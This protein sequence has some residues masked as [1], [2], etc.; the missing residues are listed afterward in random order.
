MKQ[1]YWWMKGDITA[2]ARKMLTLVENRDLAGSFGKKGN[3]R[4]LSEFTLQ[5][6]IATIDRLIEEI[7]LI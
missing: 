3:A 5:K 7:F 6:H 1:A 4:I 2:M